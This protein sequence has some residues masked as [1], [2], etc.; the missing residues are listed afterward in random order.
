MQRDL[1]AEA[2]AV[3]RLVRAVKQHGSLS[4]VVDVFRGANTKAVKDRGHNTLPE[5]GAGKALRCSPGLSP[6]STF[7]YQ[8]L[9]PDPGALP[10]DMAGVPPKHHMC[11]W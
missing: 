9:L 3:V 6:G 11:I 5:H 8:H 1:T 4:H 2:L 10:A 7:A